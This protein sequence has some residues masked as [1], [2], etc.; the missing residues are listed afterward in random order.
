[1]DV[2]GPA[3]WPGAGSPAAQMMKP[4]PT[5]IEITRMERA[6]G[7]P[8]HYVRDRRQLAAVQLVAPGRSRNRDLAWAA[9]KMRAGAS[10]V[11]NLNRDGLDAIASGLRRDRL[12][13]FR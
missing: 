8:G 10:F 2:A 1:M 11:R 12:T 3:H 6:I 4:R 13:L 7:W 9:R 5:S